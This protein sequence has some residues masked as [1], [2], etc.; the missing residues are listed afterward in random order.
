MEFS[1][2]AAQHFPAAF[3]DSPSNGNTSLQTSVSNLNATFSRQEEQEQ[4]RRED[5]FSSDAIW[6][7]VAVIATIGNIV[8]VAVVC[9]C[10][11]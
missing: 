1:L 7:W 9:A 10:A 8:V 5:K 4:D 6:L 2:I 11:F 3:T